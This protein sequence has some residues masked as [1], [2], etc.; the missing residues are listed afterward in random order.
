MADNIKIALAGLI[1]AAGLGGFYYF[2]D[3]PVIVQVA[4][5]LIAAMAAIAVFYQTAAGKATWE[6][7]KSARQELRK[8]VW[9]S[10]KETMQVTLVVF[11][12]VVLVALFLWAVDWGLLKGMRALTGR[13]T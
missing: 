13:G 2:G 9:P 5:L 10:N 7:V 8:V 12:M 3:Q 11:A 4:I 1:V 6:F